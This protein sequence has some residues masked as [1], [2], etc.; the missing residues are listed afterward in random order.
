MG[1]WW[2]V[3]DEATASVDPATDNAIQKLVREELT[4][5]TVLCVAH[6]LHTICFYDRVLVLD[7]GVAVEYDTP[8]ALLTKP[9]PPPPPERRSATAVAVGGGGIGVDGGVGT[10]RGTAQFRRLAERSGDY[11]VM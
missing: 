11:E 9:K 10:A 3:V 2:T 7:K 1:S 4:D 6:R 5:M 8:L